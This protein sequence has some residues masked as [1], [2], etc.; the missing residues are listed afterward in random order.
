MPVSTVAATH[1]LGLLLLFARTGHCQT[2]I[3]RDPDQR[4][5]DMQARLDAGQPAASRWWYGWIGGYTA[6]TLA[7]GAVFAQSSDPGVRANMVVGTGGSLFGVLCTLVTR[8]PA[9]DAGDAL[10]AGSSSGSYG[11]RVALGERL[12]ND[13]ADAELLGRSWLAHGIGAVVA[14]AQG[15]V[16]WLGYRRPVD[17]A[18]S[19][20]SSLAIS[21]V[22]IFSQPIRAIEDRDQY[23]KALVPKLQPVQPQLGLAMLPPVAVIW[24]RF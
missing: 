7:Q 13:S 11:A 6:L 19:F 10:R 16:L 15:L 23:R 12:L 14:S 5:V 9:I 3:S 4:L 21:E 20:A 18:I 2:A 17:G 22:Q 8:L 24:A 1:A